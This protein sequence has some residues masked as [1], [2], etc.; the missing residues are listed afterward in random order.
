MKMPMIVVLAGLLLAGLAGC[1]NSAQSGSAA[2]PSQTPAQAPSSEAAI[3]T[4]IQEHLEHASN[5]NLQAFDTDVKQVTV[6]GDHA[7]AQVDFHI[8]GGPGVMQM[9]YQIENRQGTWAVV[10]SNPA[11][12]DFSHAPVDQSRSP[13]TPAAPAGN[14]DSLADTLCSFKEGGAAGAPPDLPPGHSPLNKNTTSAP[15]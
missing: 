2:S 6:Q 5:L 12:S 7:Q 14:S 11:G 15:Q 3:R 10:E 9:T 1:Q 8:K 13:G 4:A